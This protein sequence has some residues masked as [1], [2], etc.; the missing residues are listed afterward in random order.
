MN[1][2]DIRNLVE[3]Y[4]NVYAEQ[5]VSEDMYSTVKGGLE[6][7]AEALKNS[8][9]GGVVKFL[10]GPVGS[11]KGKRTPSKKDQDRKIKANEDIE[12]YNI[13]F[14]HLIE[15][16]FASSE[17]NAE[18]IIS[19]M[20]DEWISNILID[21]SMMRGSRPDSGS[22]SGSNGIGGVV[23]AVTNTVKPYVQN[24][25]RKKYGPLGGMIAGGEVDKIGSRVKSGDY[26]GALSRVVQGAGKLFN[27]VD[28]FDIVKGHLLDEGYADTEDAAIN[29]MANMSEEWKQS[30]VEIMRGSG[31]GR[32]NGGY[33]TRPGDGKPYADGPLWDSKQKPE[34]VP[35]STKSSPTKKPT[36]KPTPGNRPE[37]PLW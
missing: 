18:K 31:P 32:P 35:S 7:G 8:P 37:G 24:Q 14:N 5:E 9:A 36:P 29:I 1:S 23:D 16:G 20:S 10:V 2:K 30:I 6:K 27:S 15:E 33:S 3:S 26:G 28:M 12:L 17:E 4:Q 25:A 19:V 11:N 22:S 34:D 21:E 13:V